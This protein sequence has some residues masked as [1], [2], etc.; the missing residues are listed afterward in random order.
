[1]K[2]LTKAERQKELED[3]LDE[4]PFLIDRELADLFNVSIQTIRLDRME[5]GIPEV[6]ERIKAVAKQANS[7]VKSVQ[8]EEIIGELVDIQLNQTGISILEASDDLVLEKTKIVRGHH[9]F[10]QANSLAVAII[11]A[12]VALTGSAEVR[13]NRPVYINERLVA[14]AKVNKIIENRFYVKVETKINGETVFNG[15]FIIFSVGDNLVNKE[16]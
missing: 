16:G 8:R 15:E 13:Y 5:L 4:D 3:R 6:R 11:D 9:I 7:K 1:M 2:K 14:K 10:A 12:D